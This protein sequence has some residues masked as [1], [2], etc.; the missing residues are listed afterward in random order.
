MK[1]YRIGYT[2]GTFD[3]FHVGH[4]NIIKNAK[5]QCD[6]LIVGVNSDKL[7]LEYKNKT[8]IISEN[9]RAAIVGAL[10]GV[11]KVIITGTLDKLKI[12]EYFKYD[13]IFI[14]SDW[15][16]NARW[17][18]TK[19]ELNVIGVDVVFLPHTDGISSTMIRSQCEFEKVGNNDK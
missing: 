16:E 7:V 3:L 19:E 15:K 4:L 1:K 11:D 18:K 9:D 13:A 17:Q 8:P 14:G 10:K 12:H 6:Y 5:K 2:Q